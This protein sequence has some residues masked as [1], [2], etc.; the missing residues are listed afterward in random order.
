MT[1]SELRQNFLIEEL[2]APGSATAVYTHYDRLLLI[3]AMPDREAIG[4][5]EDMARVVAATS[6]L[7]DA[8]WG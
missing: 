1:G 5:G 7:K 8:N 6:F 3:G 4:L 2:F